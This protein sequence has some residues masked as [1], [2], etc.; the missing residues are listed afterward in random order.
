[1]TC[2]DVFNV[3]FGDKDDIVAGVALRYRVALS[4]QSAGPRLTVTSHERLTDWLAGW[5]DTGG[6]AP[7]SVRLLIS[8]RRQAV[9]MVTTFR[10]GQQQQ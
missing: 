9:V 2:E 4:F 8:A 3:H 1:M 6:F 10:I 5:A 7:G